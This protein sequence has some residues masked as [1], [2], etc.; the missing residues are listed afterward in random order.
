MYINSTNTKLNLKHG[1]VSQLLLKTSGDDL[2][3]ECSVH[4]PL[5]PGQVAVTGAKNLKC[6][7]IFHIALPKYKTANS[8][9]V[10]CS[11]S[12]KT[13]HIY[14]TYIVLGASNNLFY[15]QFYK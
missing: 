14:Y 3:K 10:S 8:E 15:N 7:K 6:N 9:S 13:L 1:Q 11:L 5:K 2:Q 12:T 4:A